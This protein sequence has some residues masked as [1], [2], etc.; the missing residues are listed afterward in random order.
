MRRA[1]LPI[2]LLLLLIL[3]AAAAAEVPS[4]KG[5]EPGEPASPPAASKPAPAESDWWSLASLDK[6]FPSLNANSWADVLHIGKWGGALGLGYDT[7]QQR[8]TTPGAPSQRFASSIM[9]ESVAVSN[10]N[11]SLIDPLLLTGNARLRFSLDQNQQSVDTAITRQQGQLT[12]YSVDAT[13]LSEKA[14]PTHFFANRTNNWIT[15]PSGGTTQGVSENRGVIFRLRENSILRDR[16]ILPYF[17]AS[18]SVL[19]N[20][21]QEVTTVAGQSFRR[22]DQRSAIGMSC[23]NGFETADLDFNYEHADF[24]N[25]SFPLGNYQSQSGGLVYSLDFGQNLD[26]RSDSRLNFSQRNGATSLSTVTFDEL[27]TID[28]SSDLQSAYNYQLARQSTAAGTVT[29]QN[30]GVAVQHR[31]YGNLITGAGLTGSLQALPN[32]SIESKGARL[33]FNYFHALPWRGQ[34]NAWL[35]GSYTV[36]S[37]KLQAGL[38]SVFD[39]AFQAPQQ[40]GAGAGFLLKD[41]FIVTSS[42]VVVAIKGGARVPTTAG[43]DYQVVVEGDQTRILPQPT[44]AV[45]LPGDSLAVSYDFRVDPSVTYQSTSRSMSIGADWEWINMYFSHSEDG[46]RP[47]SGG[48]GSLLSSSSRNSARLGL[49]GG[50]GALRLRGDGTLLRYNSNTQSYVD[51]RL[52]QQLTYFYDANDLYV[53]L[54][55]NEYRTDYLSPAHQT[56]GEEARLDVGLTTAAGWITTSYLSR[57]NYRDTQTGPETFTETG[58]KLDRK[59][60]KLTVAMVFALSERQ[61]GGVQS[62]NS[63][64]HVSAIRQ[65]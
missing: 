5:V 21:T 24:V 52:T 8:I 36:T 10:E 56:V 33:G 47:L 61:R 59:W 25:R 65:F 2:P 43:I 50:R 38:V 7:T 31:L 54:S 63:L 18:A 12:D 27:L 49:N 15:Q 23:H 16:E 19:Q 11:F 17:S 20:T 53:T 13:L 37:N 3:Q 39:A 1:T 42:L 30:A 60:N 48:D 6:S 57:R 29:A 35:G 4:A 34:L 44:S 32:G 46:Q 14:Y 26:R 22:D 45:I 58:V 51:A 55:A 28:H 62:H 9:R 41:R 40:L 64:L